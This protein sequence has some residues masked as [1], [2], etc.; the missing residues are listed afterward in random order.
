MATDTSLV[1]NLLAK[2]KV[3]PELKKVNAGFGGLSSTIKKFALGA[4]AIFGGFQAIGFLKDSLAQYRDAAK[5]GRLTNQVIASTGGIAGITADHVHALATKLQNLAGV[6]DDVIA[7]GENLLLTMTSVRNG[8]GAGNNVF[9]R[10]TAAALDMSAALGRDLHGSI[11][12]VGRALQDPLKGMNALRRAQVI[13]T[14]DQ[15]KAIKTMMAQGNL[16]GAQKVL[17][18]ALEQKFKGAAAAA[19]DPMQKASVAWGNFK[20][21]IGSLVYPAVMA[22]STYMN[23]KFIPMLQTGIALLKTGWTDGATASA[24][25]IQKVGAAAHVAAQEVGKFLGWFT[26]GSERA[27]LLRDIAVG[28]G[29]VTIAIRLATAAQI[30]WNVATSANPWILLAEAIVAL[31]VGIY[32]LWTHSAGFRK[33]FIAAWHDIWG[34]LKAVGGWFAGPFKNFFVTAWRDITGFASAAWNNVLKPVFDTIKSAAHLLVQNVTSLFNLLTYPIKAVIAPAV[35]WLWHSVFEPAFHGIAAVAYWLWQTVLAPVWDGVKVVFADVMKDVHRLGDVFSTVFGAIGAV[36]SKNFNDTVSVVKGAING[37]I[38]LLNSAI[39]FIN[40][41]IIDKV[42]KVPGVNFGHLVP[43]PKL[44]TGGTILQTGIA[45]VHK[46][47]TVV[48]ARQS[49]AATAHRTV[50]VSA[51]DALTQY[52]LDKI[53]AEVRNRYGGDVTVALA[54]Y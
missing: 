49:A 18:A 38:G 51:G 7:G 28:V 35:L 27:K 12:I 1:F 36:I 29:A 4:T 43:I 30:A 21:T 16:M 40:R 13:L 52:V 32:Y 14:A 34:V 2:D 8:I 25:A 19:T 42:N 48:P 46:G 3:S 23:N 53:R 6:D 44:D 20:E 9:D 39:G 5:V 11:L 26:G 31:G 33:F 10:A 37:M 50:T 47:E 41:D 45:V 15:Q 22:F 17:L 24:G 54:G